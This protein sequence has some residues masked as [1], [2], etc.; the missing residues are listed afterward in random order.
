M[1]ND[2]SALPLLHISTLSGQDLLLQAELLYERSVAALFVRLEVAKVCTSVSNHLEKSTTGVKVLRIFL[3]ML[4][5]V[6]NL[7]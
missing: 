6:V 1:L 4:S 5:Q 2:G 7:L 3:E